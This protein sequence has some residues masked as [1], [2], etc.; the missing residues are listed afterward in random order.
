MNN[1]RAEWKKQIH[2]AD[3][4]QLEK[5]L[6]ELSRIM[7][8]MIKFQQSK[9]YIRKLILNDFRSEQMI[10]KDYG[11]IFKLANDLY[12]EG[13]ERVWHQGHHKGQA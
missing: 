13:S 1:I 3:P 5:G 4:M 9:I 6:D 12:Q 7:N 11:W 10:C 8:N 2:V